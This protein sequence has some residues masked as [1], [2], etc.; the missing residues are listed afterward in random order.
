ML[1]VLLWNP[2]IEAWASL[3][4]SRALCTV[5]I[6]VM[7]IRVPRLV[8]DLPPKCH[9]WGIV[10]GLVD[11]C[12]EAAANLLWWTCFVVLLDQNESCRH[13]CLH[14]QLKV[15]ELSPPRGASSLGSVEGHFPVLF[16]KSGVN[17][18]TLS[19]RSA[20]LLVHTH[21]SLS[22]PAARRLT[23]GYD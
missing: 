2:K 17:S 4:L 6:D 7:C 18:R 3:E 9:L 20:L 23:L 22:F 13:Q 12:W 15:G 1:C 14:E 21:L 11:G 10:S 5:R 16:Q 19:R 8:S